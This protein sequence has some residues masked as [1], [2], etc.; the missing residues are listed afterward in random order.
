MAV[1]EN[2]IFLHEEKN[3]VSIDVTDTGKGIQKEFA[4]HIY[5]QAEKNKLLNTPRKKFVRT[6]QEF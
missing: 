3:G 5:G 6:G 1:M 4:D 2:I